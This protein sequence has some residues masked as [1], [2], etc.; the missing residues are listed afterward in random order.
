MNLIIIMII[1]NNAYNATTLIYFNLKNKINKTRNQVKNCWFFFSFL[2]LTPLRTLL[3]VHSTGRNPKGSAPHHQQAGR[4]W[5]AVQQNPRLRRVEKRRQSFRSDRSGETDM[6]AWLLHFLLSSRLPFLEL[7]C[8][9][10]DCSC[11]FSCA[12]CLQKKQARNSL[13]RSAIKQGLV[14]HQGGLSSWWSFIMAVSHQGGLSSGRTL[15]LIRVVLSGWSLIRVV[16]HQG[17]LSSWQSLI[18]VVFHQGGLSISSGW[19]CQGGLSSG[20]SFIRVVFHYGSLSSGWSFIR[21]DSQSHQGGLV[22]VVPHQGGLSSGWSLIR[23][24]SPSHQGGLVR[25]VSHQG[26]LSSGWSLIREDSISSGWSFIMAVSHQ[27]GIS[28][29]RTRQGGLSSWQSLIRWSFI[30]VVFH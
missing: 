6:A 28:L 13:W 27:G 11:G 4:V 25:V 23:E 19:S 30:R 20:W 15:N 8:F 16:F 29:G 18:R 1:I 14:S 3:C 17:G 21:E 2:F 10:L 7:F 26:G 22:R 24:D 9:I 5:L 12:S